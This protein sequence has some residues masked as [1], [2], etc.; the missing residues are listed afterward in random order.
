MVYYVQCDL[1]GICTYIA[2]MYTMY[3]TVHP[4]FLRSIRTIHFFCLLVILHVLSSNGKVLVKVCT[5][6]HVVVECLY[7]KNR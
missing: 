2:A 7:T 6:V 5:L 3:N 4:S 1:R